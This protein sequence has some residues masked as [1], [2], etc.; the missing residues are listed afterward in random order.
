M[1]Q[2]SKPIVSLTYDGT[3]LCHLETAVPVLNSNGLKATFYADPLMLLDNLPDWKNVQSNGHEIG[4]GSLFE[5]LSSQFE[6]DPFS[7]DLVG[8]DIDETDNLIK[9][10]FPN[11]LSFSLAYPWSESQHGSD[12]IRKLVGSRHSICRSG[13]KGTNSFDSLE[14][15]F[16]RC[17]PCHDLTG[18]QMITILQSSTRR[19]EWAILAFDGIGSGER[20]IDA[21]AHE[22]VVFWLAENSDICEVRPVTQSLASDFKD[23]FQPLKLV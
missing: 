20:G 5:S 6:F 9:E 13:V 4:N 21:S 10:I 7:L 2:I 23:Q 16:L 17:I 14:C 18:A 15:S 1:P 22:E 12:Q 8:D 19:G 11:Q 3:Q